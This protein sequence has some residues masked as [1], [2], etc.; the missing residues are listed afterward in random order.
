MRKHFLIYMFLAV[1]YPDRDSANASQYGC[2][3]KSLIL[4]VTSVLGY[5]PISWFSWF[6]GVFCSLEINWFQ[7]PSVFSLS[8]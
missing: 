4:V 3:S 5:R 8:V 7:D 2:L 1:L 6:S